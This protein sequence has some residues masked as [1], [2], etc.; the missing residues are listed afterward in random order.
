MSKLHTTQ[1]EAVN[2][3]VNEL[4]YYAEQSG[5]DLTNKI[6]DDVNDLDNIFNDGGMARCEHFSDIGW[7]YALQFGVIEDYGVD[8]GFEDRLWSCIDL[9]IKKLQKQWNKNK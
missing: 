3:M 2:D 5:I 4:N 7:T 6:P 8:G 9:A 1:K